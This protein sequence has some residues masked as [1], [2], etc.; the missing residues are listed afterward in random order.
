[1]LPETADLS[2]VLES[3]ETNRN[4]V[5]FTHC[6]VFGAESTINFNALDSPEQTPQFATT[7]LDD[8]LRSLPGGLQVTVKLRSRI[9]GD[10]TVGTLI[11]GT[12][13]SDVK[14][15]RTV[16]IPNGSPV[17]G[18]IRRL[19]KYTSPFPYFIVG[20]EFTE[21]EIQGIRHLFYADLADIEEPP[22]VEQILSTKNTVRT[23][24][25]PLSF[26]NDLSTTQIIESTRQSIERLFLYNLPGVATFFY[27]G[28]K[29][30]LA[31]DFRTVWKTRS[32]KR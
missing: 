9:S 26:G 8:T 6:R 31:Q 19:E 12:V 11:E 17:R 23:E 1:L 18:R 32:L 30:D 10:M 15:K 25:D 5:E 28:S 16:V 27:K 21:V 7:T 29:L 22:G 4:L 2:L 13:G 14:E 3:G 20:L 24:T